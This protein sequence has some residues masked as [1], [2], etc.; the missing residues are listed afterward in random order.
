M[1]SM[2]KPIERRE[3]TSKD[4]LKKDDDDSVTLMLTD[5]IDQEEAAR[6][7]AGGHITPEKGIV[8]KTKAV[9]RKLPI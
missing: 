7:G 9:E 6:S 3:N 8:T 1:S 2:P 4:S 5:D